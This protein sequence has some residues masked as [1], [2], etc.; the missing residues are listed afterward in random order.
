MIYRAETKEIAKKGILRLKERWGKIYP[1]VV[2]KWEEK[3]I[4]Y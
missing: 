3:R 4:H 1:K 2:K